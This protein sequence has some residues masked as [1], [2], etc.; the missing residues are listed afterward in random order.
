[1]NKP[2]VSLTFSILGRGEENI[3]MYSYTNY[4]LKLYKNNLNFSVPRRSR[5]LK[6][7][8]SY[9]FILS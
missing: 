3:F 6:H 7:S 9:G 5:K 1:M 4:N 8:L 2:W